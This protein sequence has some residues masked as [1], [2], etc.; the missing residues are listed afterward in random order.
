MRDERLYY[1]P[2]IRV[3]QMPTAEQLMG[4]ASVYANRA[5]ELQQAGRTDDAQSCKEVVD[6]LVESAALRAVSSSTPQ[7]SSPRVIK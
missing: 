4:A 7:T 6:W 3:L 2:P 1:F 5:D